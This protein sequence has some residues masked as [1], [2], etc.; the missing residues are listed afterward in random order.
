MLHDA[1]CLHNTLLLATLITLIGYCS[2]AKPWLPMLHSAWTFRSRVHCCNKRSVARF[3]D[4]NWQYQWYTGRDQICW[5]WVYLMTLI[6]WFS[7]LT[8]TVCS[9]TML[10]SFCKATN[11]W[12]WAAEC[13]SKPLTTSG[14]ILPHFLGFHETSRSA[15]KNLAQGMR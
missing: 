8:M 9:A 4:S 10:C 15:C 14:K 5:S 6:C 13:R 3:A 12:P 11:P 2:Q 7:E 1:V